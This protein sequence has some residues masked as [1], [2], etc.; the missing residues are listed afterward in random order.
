MQGR[1]SEDSA[2]AETDACY[3]LTAIPGVECLA[4]EDLGF[5]RDYT[6]FRDT[7]PTK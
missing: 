3:A 2:C 5:S 4:E 6:G 1:C 7:T